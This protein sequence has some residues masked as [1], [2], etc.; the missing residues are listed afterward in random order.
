[1]A[2]IMADRDDS[3]EEE[4]EFLQQRGRSRKVT[5]QEKS[6]VNA[7]KSSI[8][9]NQ[10]MMMMLASSSEISALASGSEVLDLDKSK[11][12]EDIKRAMIRNIR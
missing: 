4:N 7:R 8:F 5:F 10:D 11:K 6:R 2:N 9:M 3:S 1:M 12:K